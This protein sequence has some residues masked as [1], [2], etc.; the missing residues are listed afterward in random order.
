VVALLLDGP[1]PDAEVEIQ[2]HGGPAAVALVVDA[3]EG[4]GV[5]RRPAEEW[6]AAQQASPLS[7]L[8]AHDVS[9]AETDRTARHLLAQARGALDAELEAIRTRIRDAPAEA[10]ER[11]ETLI[12]RAAVGLHLVSGWRIALAGR[13]NVGKSRLL[14]A[15][16]GYGRAIV[17]PTPG[18]TRDVVTARLAL[19][20]W[21]VE[22]ADTAGL[23]V[24]HDP[25]EA[26]GVTRARSRHGGADLVLLILDQSEPLTE[27]DRGLLAEYANAVI[28]CNKSDL[29]AAWEPGASW[30]EV[31]RISAERGDGL[32][33]LVATLSRTLVPRPPRVGDAIPFRADQRAQLGDVRRLLREGR[34]D[35]AVSVLDQLQHGG[36]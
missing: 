9:S 17:S 16:A 32:D 10:I 29:A 18:T 25:I 14:N 19:D 15:L 22:I 5:S 24:T 35:E 1:G 21:P 20:G 13:P 8:A 3:L 6:L 2:C 26:G 23:R 33:A 27:T 4:I 31:R 28:V 34:R 11:L 7:V 30:G 36:T 12:E